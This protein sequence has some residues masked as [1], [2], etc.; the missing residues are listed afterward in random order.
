MQNSIVSAEKK[1]KQNITQD[2]REA[3]IEEY[4][5]K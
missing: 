1:E 2:W 5:M 4:C 3:E